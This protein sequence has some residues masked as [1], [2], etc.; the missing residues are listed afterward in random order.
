MMQ[1]MPFKKTAGTR[2]AEK[3]V[4]VSDEPARQ[5]AAAVVTQYKV[6]SVITDEICRTATTAVATDR[7]HN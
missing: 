3:Q 7:V 4:T 6:G 5:T 1:Q 2:L